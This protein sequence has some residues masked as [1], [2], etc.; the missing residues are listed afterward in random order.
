MSEAVKG[1]AMGAAFGGVIWL[2][3]G[4]WQFFAVALVGLACTWA[5]SP[6]ADPQLRVRRRPLVRVEI[7][8]ASNI[9]GAYS[10]GM[11]RACYDY[12]GCQ[13]AGDG[14]KGKPLVLDYGARKGCVHNV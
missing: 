5:F 1:A 14:C 3:T 6:P 9:V 2:T 10:N 12:G 7:R 8:D 4:I 13:W 11:T